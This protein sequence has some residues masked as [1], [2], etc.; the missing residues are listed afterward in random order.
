MSKKQIKTFNRALLALS[1]FFLNIRPAF[2]CGLCHEDDR[3]AVYSY[4]AVQKTKAQPDKLEF[5]VF[6]VI[7]PLPASTIEKLN[8]W[9]KAQKGVDPSTLKISAQQKSI[10]FVFEKAFSKEVLIGNLQKN[11]PELQVHILKYD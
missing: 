9:L 11:F 4:E 8:A 2:P 7:G 1:V 5:A 10:G 6:K 3:S